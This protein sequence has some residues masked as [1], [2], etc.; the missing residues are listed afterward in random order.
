M[1][2]DRFLSINK[3]TSRRDALKFIKENKVRIDNIP[4][5]KQSQI[6]DENKSTVFIN[7]FPV[8]YKYPL[9]LILNKPIGYVSSKKDELAISVYK[10]L[11]EPYS[12]FDFGIGGRLDVDASG[13]LIFSTSGDIIHHITSPNSNIEKEY[14][15]TLQNE[16]D[17]TQKNRLLEGVEILDKDT[18]T[19][20]AK[21]ISINTNPLTITISSGKYH[22]VKRMFEKVGNKVLTL[23]RIRIGNIL[24][25]DL[26]EG[27]F[28]EIEIDF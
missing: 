7:D 1:R 6:F 10:L 18:K 15:V 21:A 13:L 25:G 19:Y 17:D 3:I 27:E 14:Q 2:L 22:Q 8:F 23:K 20:L 11:K 9:T 4:A 16:L 12:K 26:K 5:K 24:L 28:K